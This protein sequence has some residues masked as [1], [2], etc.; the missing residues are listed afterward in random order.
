MVAA[1]LTLAI[2]VGAYGQETT[3]TLDSAAAEARKAGIAE[4]RLGHFA[5]A[6]RLLRR[7]LEYAEQD[8]DVFSAAL[9][10]V[11]LG[12][13]YQAQ[14]Q[15]RKAQ[16]IYE[17][18]ISIFRQTKRVHAL[19]ITLRNLA[20][21]L[22]AQ[23]KYTESIRH[24]EE[25]SMLAKTIVPVDFELE[26]RILETFGVTYFGQRKV[27][28]ALESFKRS[29]ELVSARGFGMSDLNLGQMLNNLANVYAYKRQYGW[30]EDT[31]IR[32]LRVTEEQ[33]GRNHR[34]F[35]NIL[36][37]LGYLY[38]TIG[39]YEEAEVQVRQSLAIAEGSELGLDDVVIRSLHALGKIHMKRN[40][41][42]QAEATLSRA[43]AIARGSGINR[44]EAAEILETYSQLLL[45]EAQRI[46]ASSAFTIHIDNAK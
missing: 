3:S 15:F 26:L 30:A 46:R 23:R 5:E 40:E 9:N 28:K 33:F 25:A 6:D 13:I 19:A 17:E 32:A 38:M 16:Q 4:Y 1:A 2:T 36:N 29:I 11:A 21:V 12:D 18:G 14:G 41:D 7:A 24:L 35:A 27:D 43:L 10:R 39:R 45:E 8:H 44:P 37:N 22:T 34:Q 20:A 31:Y 42:E